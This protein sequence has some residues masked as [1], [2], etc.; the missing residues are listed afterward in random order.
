LPIPLTSFVG[1]EHELAAVAELVRR[2]DVRLV[3]VTGPGGVGKTRLALQLAAD[4]TGAFPDGVGF[5]SLAAIADPALVPGVVARALEPAESGDRLPLERLR[6]VLGS[7]QVLLILDNF[8]HVVEAAPF[9]VDLLTAFSGVKMLVTSRVT[10]RVSGEHEFPVE[11][12]PV[13]NPER[14]PPLAELAGFGAVALFDQRARAARPDFALDEANAAAVAEVCARLDGLPLAIELAAARSKVLSPQAMLTRLEHRLALLSGGGR[15]QPE[16]LRALREAIAWSYDLLTPHQQALF[17]QL[18]VF[19]GGCTAEAAAFVAGGDAGPASQVLDDLSSLVD[20]SLLVQRQQ[21]DGEPRF[22]ILET[23]REYGLERLASAGEEETTRRRHAEWCVSMADEF[24]P[25][26]KHGLEPAQV[27]GRLGPEHAN[28]RAALMWLDQ[29]G[30]REAVLRLAGAISLYWYVHEDLREGLAWL[31]CALDDAAEMPADIPAPAQLGAGMLSHYVTDD[32]R[33]VPWAEA[34]LALYRTVDDAWGMAFALLL[35]G[36]VSEDAG[37][38]DQ[39]ASYFSE[40][41]VRARA[42]ENRVLTGLSLIHLGVVAWGQGDRERATRW[43]IDA[44]EV[45]RANGGVI[46]GAAESLAFLG[47]LACE[48]GD[49]ARSVELHRESLSLHVERGYIEVLAVNLADVAI[50]ALAAG[51]PERAVRLFG[52]AV[53]QR[54]AIGNPFKLPERDVYER[55]T[56]AAREQ[57]GDRFAAA[58]NAGRACSLADA[59]ADA[60]ATL[61]EFDGLATSTSISAPPGIE[62]SLTSREL[63][64]LRLL[65]AGGSNREIADALF[66]SHRTVQAHV[67][68]LFAKLD[69]HSRAAAVSRAYEL[70]LV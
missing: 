58:W 63:E 19:A 29:T 46:Y 13:P 38:Y 21:R 28:L 4:S 31:E 65:V 16:R 67:A 3:T 51:R 60:F 62:A 12:L 61:D 50:L 49:L 41:L 52:A 18:A 11:P 47:L 55:G 33:A 44:L 20:S 42:A 2:H 23:I 32:V 15:D 45:Q 5:I 25:T 54:D 8:E 22:S 64:V 24:W 53:A 7:K 34:S 70:G 69:V 36:I 56:A 57:L 35:L 40:S 27:I 30:D 6:R 59:V 1:R 68:N 10:L 39:A 37:N 26:L 14:L 48:S 66:V 17:R 43:V 9:V